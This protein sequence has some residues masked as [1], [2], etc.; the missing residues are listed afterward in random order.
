MILVSNCATT[1]CNRSQPAPSQS[2]PSLI[3]TRA[4]SRD[5]RVINPLKLPALFPNQKLT[6]IESLP[7]LPNFAAT[8]V[9]KASCLIARLDGAILSQGK[10]EALWDKVVTGAPRPRTP[11]EL[12]CSDPL[13]G[14]AM[15]SMIL[16]EARSAR[17]AEQGV[18]S[19]IWHH[20]NDC[21]KM[22]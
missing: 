4:L 16:R 3:T 13:P 14:R 11:S 10:K 6:A 18:R 20:P 19:G 15:R 17:A 22:A 12:Q 1:L 7:K 5:K 2:C 8:P 9:Q 21:R